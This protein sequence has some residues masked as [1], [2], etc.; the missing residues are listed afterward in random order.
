MLEEEPAASLGKGMA[1]QGR[2][3]FPPCV[4]L[5]TGGGRSQLLYFPVLPAA[6]TGSA[7]K[8]EERRSRELA[9]TGWPCQRSRN[10]RIWPK[11]AACRS[12]VALVKYTYIVLLIPGTPRP[13]VK[14]IYPNLCL[15]VPWYLLLG[16]CSLKDYQID[17]MCRNRAEPFPY[18][19]TLSHL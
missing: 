11:K 15:Y 18:E 1:W 12:L 16:F 3:Q 8:P 6:W 19:Q 2:A 10:G 14:Y 7:Q 5:E 4:P 9:L 13:H 17:L